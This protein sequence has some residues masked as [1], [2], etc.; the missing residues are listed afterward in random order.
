METIGSPLH[1]LLSKEKELIQNDCLPTL[2]YL[3]KRFSVFLCPL[4]ASC[5]KSRS[6]EVLIQTFNEHIMAVIHEAHSE[7]YSYYYYIK[8]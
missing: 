7:Y 5:N 8:M 4:S 6:H 1:V 3:L 2:F